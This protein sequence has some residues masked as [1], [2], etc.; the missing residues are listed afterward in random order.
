MPCIACNGTCAHG[1]Y[2]FHI[3]QPMTF[4]GF[5]STFSKRDEVT[6]SVLGFSIH[7]KQ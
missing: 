2:I 6:N 4:L 1:K 5:R 3:T 7:P